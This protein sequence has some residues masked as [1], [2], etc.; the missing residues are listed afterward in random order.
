M[1]HE[2]DL[3]SNACKHSQK[4]Q[5]IIIYCFSFFLFHFSK[6]ILCRHWNCF[7]LISLCFMIMF[8]LKNTT[9]VWKKIQLLYIYKQINSSTTYFHQCPRIHFWRKYRDSW[10]WK[11]LYNTLYIEVKNFPNLPLAIIRSFISLFF[12]FNNAIIQGFYYLHKILILLLFYIS[13]A[14]L[15]EK[16]YSKLSSNHKRLFYVLFLFISTIIRTQFSRPYSYFE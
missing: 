16:K 7:I 5:H 10:T 1:S 6:I 12:R 4:K 3:R 14:I 13:H 2:R 15:D 8:M 11:M 9:K